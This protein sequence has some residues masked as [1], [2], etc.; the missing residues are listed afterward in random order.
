LANFTL[1]LLP[2]LNLQLHRR[3]G[4]GVTRGRTSP[5]DGRA[6]TVRLAGAVDGFIAGAG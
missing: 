3:Y 4:L 6:G 5:D 2:E 1:T